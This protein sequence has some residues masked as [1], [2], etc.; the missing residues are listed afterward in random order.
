MAQITV[1][2]DFGT[3]Q[4]KVC[5]ERK[6]GAELDYHFFKF[7]DTFG[8]YQFT[9]PS[10]V[11]INS[12]GTLEYGYVDKSI[13]SRIIRYFKQAAF[14]TVKTD[15]NK[16]EAMLY[17]IWYIAFVLFE[18]EEVYGQNFTIQMGVPS[19]GSHLETQRAVGCICDAECVPF[20]GGRV[21]Q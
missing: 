21:W 16:D 4:T 7:P 12:N 8:A 10:I 1:G 2:L 9:I 17:S 20:G 5:V 18:L 14:T 19:D 13:G 11:K 6:E 3:H 15:L